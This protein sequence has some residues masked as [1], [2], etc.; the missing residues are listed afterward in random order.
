MSI[1][2]VWTDGRTEGLVIVHPGYPVLMGFRSRLVIQA[3]G[4]ICT[5]KCN[6]LIIFSRKVDI[7]CMIPFVYGHFLLNKHK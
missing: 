5:S 2:S 1:F 4:S 6:I 3:S 7:I